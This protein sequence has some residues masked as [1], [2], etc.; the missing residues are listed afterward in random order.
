MA[1]KILVAMLLAANSAACYNW[2][3][4]PPSP[5][6]KVSVGPSNVARVTL[7]DGRRLEVVDASIANDTLRAWKLRDLRERGR[8]VPVVI[9]VSEIQLVESRHLSPGKTTAL[10]LGVAAPIALMIGLASTCMGMVC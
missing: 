8:R 6:A 1:T 9:P 5:D 10:A 2:R 4:E 7:L 3:P